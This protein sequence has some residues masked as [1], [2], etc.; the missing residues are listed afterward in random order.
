M[1]GEEIRRAR[2]AR[3]MTQEQLATAIGVG[4][5]TIRGWELDETV[6]RNRMGMLEKFFGVNDSEGQ[7]AV[8]R[9]SDAALLTELLRRAIERE[10][11]ATG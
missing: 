10:H 5:R 7:T 8:N 1:N 4:V 3:G 11:R 2:E 9:A 6:P